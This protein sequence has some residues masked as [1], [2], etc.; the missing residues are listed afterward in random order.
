MII[1]GKQFEIYGVRR[2]IETCG[3]KVGSG[4][5]QSQLGYVRRLH[6]V[7]DKGIIGCWSG[8]L[9][10]GNRRWGWGGRVVLRFCFDLHGSG[11]A[12]FNALQ[13]SYRESID[14][15]WRLAYLYKISNDPRRWSHSTLFCRGSGPRKAERMESSASFLILILGSPTSLSTCDQKI[16]KGWQQKKRKKEEE[17]E[18]MMVLSHGYTHLA[19]GKEVLKV[20]E[21]CDQKGPK[22]YFTFP[23]LAWRA[24]LCSYVIQKFF[25]LSLKYELIC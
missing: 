17:E 2:L 14:R 11:T 10:C 21:K 12:D 15:C 1:W 16:E 19:A 3:G 8:S 20:G 5:W 7:L 13:C 24:R 9:A 6:E 23:T 22:G 25:S 4:L 18:W